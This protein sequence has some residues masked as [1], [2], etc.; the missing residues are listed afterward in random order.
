MTFGDADPADA[1]DAADD[2][3]DVVTNLA[4]RVGA[5]FA[6]LDDPAVLEA[7]LS[8]WRTVAG[9]NADHARANLVADDLATLRRRLE[10]GA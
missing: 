5:L 7:A 8:A 3:A 10:G 2:P 9:A 1:Y 6:G 4:R